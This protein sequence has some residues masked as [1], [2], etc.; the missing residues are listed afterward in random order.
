MDS[1]CVLLLWSRDL[2]GTPIA[3]MW[4]VSNWG[5]RMPPR[6]SR[7][8]TVTKSRIVFL[9]LGLAF[10]AL[11]LHQVGFAPFVEAVERVRWGF[12]PIVCMNILWY[13]TDAAGLYFVTRGHIDGRPPGLGRVLQTQVCGEALNNA[14]PFMNLGGEP[15]KGMLLREWISGR[16]AVGTL[17]VDNTLKY[18]A[19]ILFVGAGLAL[20]FFFLDLP[21]S[22]RWPLVAVLMVFAGLVGFLAV[23]QAH[24]VLSRGLSLIAKLPFRIRDLEGKLERARAVDGDMARFYREKKREFF[25]SLT[26]HL[27]SRFLAALD[28]WLVLWFLGVDVAALTA[29]F[30]LSISILI[31]LAFAFIPLAMGA[32]E[33]GHFFL[34]R[35]MGLSP[36]TGVVF[37]LIGR[38]RGFVWIGFGLLLIS[39]ISSRESES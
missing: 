29:L 34:F 14:T 3:V 12:L 5:L 25:L 20:S 8:R 36:A 11:A 6:P 27:I 32:S 17:I 38:I 35:V 22:V 39:L 9:G 26:L 10:L 33:G 15:M 31:N 21:G 16:A 30:I 19:T 37:A 1:V 2:V 18:V 4:R 23:S 28:A 13:F 7:N 24:G